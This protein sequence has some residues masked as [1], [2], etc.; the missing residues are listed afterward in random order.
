MADHHGCR[1][2]A[3]AYSASQLL[4]ALHEMKSASA[5]ISLLIKRGCDWRRNPERLDRLYAA[6]GAVTC[7]IEETENEFLAR[8]SLINSK[9][10]DRAWLRADLQS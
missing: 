9:V 10:S 8:W 1:L 3:K 6:K 7:A 2:N 5:L 4:D